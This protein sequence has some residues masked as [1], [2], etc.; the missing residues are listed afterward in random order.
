MWICASKLTSG[1][2]GQQH[3]TITGDTLCFGFEKVTHG[4]IT[5][6]GCPQLIFCCWNGLGPDPLR[7]LLSHGPYA[8][9][10]CPCPCRA[11]N[12]A[13]DKRSW[14]LHAFSF[15]WQTFVRSIRLSVL[16]CAVWE[17]SSL[18][19]F[20]NIIHLINALCK[21]VPKGLSLVQR[22][23]EHL[24]LRFSPLPFPDSS[25]VCLFLGQAYQGMIYI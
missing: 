17:G 14:F 15:P 23:C 12:R 2:S 5:N 22:A 3:L 19:P 18:L 21:K 6:Q 10:L 9:G 11:Q 20:L 24:C 7:A 1:K 8:D 25:S 4:V 13:P 16:W